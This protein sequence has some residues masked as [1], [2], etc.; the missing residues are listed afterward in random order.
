MTRLFSKVENVPLARRRFC[1]IGDISHSLKTVVFYCFLNI[2][3]F[4]LFPF[5]RKKKRLKNYYF[6]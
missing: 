1:Y 6:L 3:K 2:I 5:L 4:V